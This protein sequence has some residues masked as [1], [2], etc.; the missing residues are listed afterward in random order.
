MNY[1]VKT[2][3]RLTGLNRSTLLAWER[4]YGVVEPVRADNGYRWYSESDVLRLRRLKALV[5]SGH[6][7]GEALGLLDV[8]TPAADED[9]VGDRILGRLMDYDRSGASS[10]AAGL[11]QATPEDQLRKVWM[12]LLGKLGDAWERGE[13]S[14]AQ[15]HFASGFVREHM[16]TLLRASRGRRG[17]RPLAALATPPGERHE[18]GLLG[19][20]IRL[21]EDGFGVDWLGLEL[22]LE[23]LRAYALRAQPELVGV[24]VIRE[25]SG[26]QLRR[27]AESLRAALPDRTVLAI[28]GAAVATMPPVEG[29]ELVPSGDGLAPVMARVR[30][31]FEAVG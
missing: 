15:E 5:D 19:A 25:R 30:A 9:L 10:L 11:G 1:G 3:C 14:V 6:R 24:S 12:P 2:V 28:G 16:S 26:P 20:A 23:E 31:S 22:P 13:T 7:V 4:R 29:V 18:L 27:L 17:S 21:S 8:G